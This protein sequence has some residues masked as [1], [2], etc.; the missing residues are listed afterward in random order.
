MCVRTKLIFTFCDSLCTRCQFATA[1]V[2]GGKIDS[3]VL[4]VCFP[5][6]NLKKNPLWIRKIADVICCI[7]QYSWNKS[8]LNIGVCRPCAKCNCPQSPHNHHNNGN[9]IGR[10]SGTNGTNKIEIKN[11]YFCC[12]ASRPYSRSFQCPKPALTDHI[13]DAFESESR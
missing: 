6:F 13:P 11:K 9:R 3:V 12:I 7:L 1:T 8:K 4:C 2:D 5:L 10:K